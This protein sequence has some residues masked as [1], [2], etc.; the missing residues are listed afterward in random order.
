MSESSALRAQVSVHASRPRRHPE[1]QP[2]KHRPLQA[3]RSTLVFTAMVLLSLVWLLPIFWT[4]LTSIKPD[5][6]ITLMPPVWDFTPTLEHYANLTRSG[7]FGRFFLNSALIAGGSTAIAVVISAPAAYSI[8]RFGTGGSSIKMAILGS[9]MIPPVVIAFPLFVLFMNLHLASNLTG[10]VLVHAASLAPFCT[11]LMVGFIQGV[12]RE[13]EESGLIDGCSNMGVLWRI[14][15]PMILPGLATTAVLSLVS[16]WNDLFYALILANGRTQ[17]LPVAVT[18]FITGYSIKWGDL[19]AASTVILIPPVIFALL[20][21]KHL[22]R[23]LTM[24]GVK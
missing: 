1:P 24:G 8:V 2:Q 4:V 22:V 9:R 5:A 12:P 18:T 3:F 11:W 23:G 13:M 14:T 10:L 17:T 20:V 16:S 7:S 21:Q 6:V 15:L 19:T